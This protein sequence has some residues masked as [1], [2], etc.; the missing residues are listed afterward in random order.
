MKVPTPAV[1]DRSSTIRSRH[2]QFGDLRP[3]HIP[4]G[5][6]F[7]RVETQDLAAALRDHAVDARGGF[8]RDGDLHLHD[9][10]E[11]DR[12][13]LRHAFGHADAAGLAERHVGGI[14]GVVG[15]VDQR[16]RHVHHRET[17]E[18]PALQDSPSTPISTEGMNWRGTT[19]PVIFSANWKPV[20]R[21][22]GLMSRTT[23][24]N[25]PCPPDCFLCR[26][27]ISTPLRIVSL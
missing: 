13:A 10:L 14:D 25:W 18:R 23:S 2:L 22:N 6:A 27:R 17:A 21:G 26:P 5:P 9:R 16:H 3:H 4:A 11:Q 15:S 19:P 8:A 1:A 12:I 24:P 20:P 7:A